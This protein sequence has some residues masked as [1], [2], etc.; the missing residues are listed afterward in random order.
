MF[1]SSYTVGVL[2]SGVASLLDDPTT[3]FISFTP[4]TLGQVEWGG[5]G[6]CTYLTGALVNE[7]VAPE[8]AYTGLLGAM[9]GAW[10]FL[11]IR[12]KRR[13]TQRN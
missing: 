13:S 10:G 8:P 5:A 9:A 2:F 7:A 1:R 12:R 11:K 4:S 3:A 6:C